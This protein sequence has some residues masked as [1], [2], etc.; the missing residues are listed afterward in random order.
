VEG[1]LGSRELMEKYRIYRCM[2]TRNTWLYL[3]NSDAS[4]KMRKIIENVTNRPQLFIQNDVYKNTK[5][6]RNEYKL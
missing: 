2:G 1:I 3:S 5:I 4:I 6:L